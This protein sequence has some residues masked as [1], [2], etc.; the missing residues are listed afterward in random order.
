[1]PIYLVTVQTAPALTHLVEAKTNIQAVNHVTKNL[2]SV[3]K[4]TATEVVEHAVRRGV[5]VERAEDATAETETAET[6]T[7]TEE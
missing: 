6:Q 1:M 4:L 7:E 3:Q 2:V 5:L